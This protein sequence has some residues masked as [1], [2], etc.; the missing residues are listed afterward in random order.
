MGEGTRAPIAN[1]SSHVKRDVDLQATGDLHRAR[2]TEPERDRM[3]SHPNANIFNFD[4][5]PASDDGTRAQKGHLRY[6][7]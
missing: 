1:S 4:L 5:M 2:G 3:Y 6:L 7:R